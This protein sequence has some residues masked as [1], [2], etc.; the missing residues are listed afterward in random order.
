MGIPIVRGR[1]FNA[2]D[3]ETTPKVAIVNEAMAA[4]YWP[5]RDAVGATLTLRSRGAGKVAI[6]GI[7]RQSKS[8]DIGETPQ[9][10]LYLP[11]EQSSQTRMVL[12]VETAGDPSA[13]IGAVRGEV[14]TLDPNQPIYDVR[15]MASH[16][17]QQA[18]WGVRLI[19]EVVAAVGVV[20]LALSVLGLYACHRVFR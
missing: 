19:A 6:V 15:T 7:A 3:T 9:P 12:F 18:L 16:F 11:F 13:F 2:G 20:G 17:Q 14:R 10:F 5:T 8:R 4:K 1:A